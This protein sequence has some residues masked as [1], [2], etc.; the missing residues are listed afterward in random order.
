MPPAPLRLKVQESACLC[1]NSFRFRFTYPS[2]VNVK[3]TLFDE[4]NQHRGWSQYLCHLKI[5]PIDK[6]AW[7]VCYFSYKS[8]DGNVES[9]VNEYE[10]QVTV[11]QPHLTLQHY[12]HSLAHPK[13]HVLHGGVI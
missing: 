12:M 10:I 8:C 6:F 1:V 5:Y 7:L 4:E 13:M 3:R 11:G 2:L 9:F